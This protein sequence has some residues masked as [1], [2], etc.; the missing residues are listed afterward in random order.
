MTIFGYFMAYI[1][2]CG[3]LAQLIGAVHLFYFLINRIIKRGK[4]NSDKNI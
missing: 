4:L 2:I 3:V 1:I